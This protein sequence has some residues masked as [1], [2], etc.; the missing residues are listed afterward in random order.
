MKNIWD[1]KRNSGLVFNVYLTAVNPITARGI[2]FTSQSRKKSIMGDTIK[3]KKLI[4]DLG[5]QFYNQGWFPG[6]G[7]SLTIRDG[8]SYVPQSISKYQFK[9][10]VRILG[11]KLYF[12]PS[13]VQKERIDWND[14]FVCSVD[15]SI[16]EG[17]GPEKGLKQTQ[18]T[19]LFMEAYR[20]KKMKKKLK[21]Y[22]S[23]PT[24]VTFWS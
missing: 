8:I 16:L 3:F 1:E 12:S 24:G 18:C 7:G 17:P 22:L 15:G 20:G 9:D 14:V 4:A 5:V 23:G 2:K 13:G 21:Q 11:D 19:P 10:S 6:S